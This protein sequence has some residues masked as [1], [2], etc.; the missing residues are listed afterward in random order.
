MTNF[1]R[2]DIILV[3]FPFTVKGVKTMSERGKGVT[4]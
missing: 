2:G 4:H 1:K 3:H